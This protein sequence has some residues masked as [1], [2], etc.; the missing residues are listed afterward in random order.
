MHWFKFYHES[1]TETFPVGVSAYS[2]WQKNVR[3]LRKI[4]RGQHPW[5]RKQADNG[6]YFVANNVGIKLLGNLTGI[7]LKSGHVEKECYC[8]DVDHVCNVGRMVQQ[9]VNLKSHYPS[10]FVLWHTCSYISDYFL[11]TWTTGAQQTLCRQ[12]YFYPRTIQNDI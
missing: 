7:S 9:V 1:K 4:W 8:S 5:K 10:L 11:Q 6:S 3:C 12:P 2:S